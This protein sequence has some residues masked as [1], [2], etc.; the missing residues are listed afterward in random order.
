M[1][2]RVCDAEALAKDAER[3]RRQRLNRARLRGGYGDAQV[4][5]IFHKRRMF[6][7]RY[8]PVFRYL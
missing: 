3:I 6:H 5:R 4:L 1:S 8:W 2:Y 7:E